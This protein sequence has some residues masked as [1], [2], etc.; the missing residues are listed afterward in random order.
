MVPVRGV[1]SHS[2][3]RKAN[4]DNGMVTGFGCLPGIAAVLDTLRLTHGSILVSLLWLVEHIPTPPPP[5]T[6]RRGRQETPS[7][8]IPYL[9]GAKIW[10]GSIA[11][12]IKE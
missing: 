4:G 5:A 9:P 7:Q 12:L 2:C 8:L 1:L 6:R 10:L 11:L 3:L